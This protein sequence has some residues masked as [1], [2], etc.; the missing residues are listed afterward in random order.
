[1]KTSLTDNPWFQNITVE[2][3]GILITVVLVDQFA[4][5]RE[6]RR[7]RHYEATYLLAL[8]EISSVVLSGFYL[9]PLKTLNWAFIGDKS[10]L[11]VAN[12]ELIHQNAS[13][14]ERP[15]VVI[16][17]ERLRELQKQLQFLLSLS[18][19]R[20]SEAIEE[21][22]LELNNAI[23][24][25]I[26]FSDPS[27]TALPFANRQVYNCAST[28]LEAILPFVSRTISTEEYA[29]EMKKSRIARRSA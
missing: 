28:L 1:M 21:S 10:V 18:P 12:L 29:E 8:Y 23:T 4:R 13:G 6:I 20:R 16:P 15:E 2:I 27:H 24:S 14:S 17:P 26:R 5:W 7:W 11:S 25:L 22:G 9:K 19:I 3:V